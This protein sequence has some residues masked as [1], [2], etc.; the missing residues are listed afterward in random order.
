[1]LIHEI[2]KQLLKVQKIHWLEKCTNN[3]IT[4]YKYA[5]PDMFTDSLQYKAILVDMHGQMSFWKK[6][7][8]VQY[9]KKD[10]KDVW[11]NVGC[12]QN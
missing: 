8:T 11:L 10:R 4:D 1:M 7:S 9:E 2:N 6:N 12:D 3:R 5:L